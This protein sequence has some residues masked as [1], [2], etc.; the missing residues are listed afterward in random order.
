MSRPKKMLIKM[1][2]RDGEVKKELTLT[3]YQQSSK[4]SL[5]MT[6]SDT[7]LWRRIAPMMRYLGR[8]FDWDDPDKDMS[9]AYQWFV[10]DGNYFTIEI[11]GEKPRIILFLEQLEEINF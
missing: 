6:A 10:T 4:L 3:V 1:I 9:A 2:N 11:F 8:Y 5:G 7:I